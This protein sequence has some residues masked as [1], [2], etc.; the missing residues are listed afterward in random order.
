MNKVCLDTNVLIWGIRKAASQEQQHM[1][2]HT[3]KFIEYLK[4]GNTNIIIPSVVVGEFLSGTQSKEHACVLQKI[5]SLFDVV[6]FDSHAAL[7][8]SRLWQTKKSFHKT[9][10]IPRNEMKADLMIVACA[11]SSGSEVLYSHDKGLR[12]LCKGEIEGRDIPKMD[13][14][15]TLDI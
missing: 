10:D 13:H 6:D 2:N 1:I 5:S 15:I 7:I 14:Q 12:E 3:T 9:L 4:Q 8:F 11:I